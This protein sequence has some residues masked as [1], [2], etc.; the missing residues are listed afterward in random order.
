MGK[1]DGC[2]QPG[3]KEVQA[4]DSV[5]QPAV[6]MAKG[7]GKAKRPNRNKFFLPLAMAVASATE[8]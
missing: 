2:L 5:G 7:S 3:G 6:E 4:W 8:A 1:Q